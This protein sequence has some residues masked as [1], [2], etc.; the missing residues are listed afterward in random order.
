ME[1]TKD[2]QRGDS[3]CEDL[4]TGVEASGE[5]QAQKK[6]ERFAGG[7]NGDCTVRLRMW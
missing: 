1:E 3:D 4:K 6:A 2:G 5:A 7:R